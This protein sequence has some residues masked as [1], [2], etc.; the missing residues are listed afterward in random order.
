MVSFLAT[1]VSVPVPFVS[2]RRW[3]PFSVFAADHDLKRHILI[4]ECF[5]DASDSTRALVG[6][7]N[8]YSTKDFCSRAA[9]NMNSGPSSQ[10]RL[11]G[12]PSMPEMTSS[13]PEQ[14]EG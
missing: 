9:N 10:G 6:Y 3:R 8:I 1:F 14:E 11:S 12:I 4:D 5:N 2:W 7:S 13:P